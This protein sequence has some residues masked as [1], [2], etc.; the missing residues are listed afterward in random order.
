MFFL[1]RG[2]KTRKKFTLKLIIQGLLRLYNRDI[3]FNLTTTKA[4][5]MASTCKIT[6]NINDLRIHSALNIPIQ[7][8]LFSLVN[9]SSDSLNK[10]TCQYEQLQL[11]VI[12]EISFVG[13]K[14]FNIIDNKLRSITHS[15][16]FF[17]WC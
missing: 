13:A 3:H 17:W 6:F 1:I 8:T 12:N 14:M 16:Q 4:L 5:F 7:Q 9:L 15:K 10:F 2:A 11:V